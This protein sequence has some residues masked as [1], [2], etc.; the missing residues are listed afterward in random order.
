MTITTRLKEQARGLGFSLVGVASVEP[1]DHL[2]LY[3]R[4]VA[5]GRHGEMEYLAREDA[6]ARRADLRATLPSIRSAVV[7]AHEYFQEDPP[8]VPADPASRSNSAARIWGRH[9][10]TVLFPLPSMPS[11]ET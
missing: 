8:G 9:A 6:V 1:S 10:V 5:D 3:R 7:V 11:R 4:W 2:D